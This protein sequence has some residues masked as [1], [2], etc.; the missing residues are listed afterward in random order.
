MRHT[1]LSILC[2]VAFLACHA[3]FAADEP[4]PTEQAIEAGFSPDGGAEALVIKVINSATKSIRLAA[5]SFTSPPIVKALIDAK[6]KGVD[7][8][9]IADYKSNIEENRTDASRKALGLLVSA[10][11][12]T[13]TIATYSIHHDKY[14]VV[15]GLHVET[16]SY[17]FTAAAAKYN[18]ENVLVVWNVPTIA[19]SY[20]AHWQSRWEQGKPL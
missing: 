7:V 5:Y 8:A 14:I 16:G 17:N 11:I 1:L 15:D 6:K 4:M 10:G 19:A 2:S 18:S 20:I 12:P 3:A 9:V 13:R